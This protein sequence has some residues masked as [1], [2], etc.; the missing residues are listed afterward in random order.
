VDVDGGAG[1]GGL[2]VV[3][4]V[5][6]GGSSCGGVMTATSG[7]DETVAPSRIPDYPMPSPALSQR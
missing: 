1:W 2:C 6:S 5:G 7:K 3:K 4:R